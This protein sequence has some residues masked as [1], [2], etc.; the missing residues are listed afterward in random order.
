M[1]FRYNY[2]FAGNLA[3]GNPNAGPISQSSETPLIA[4]AWASVAVSVGANLSNANVTFYHDASALTTTGGATT[5]A[6][7]TD[8]SG[9]SI[10]LGTDPSTSPL[11]TLPMTGLDATLA[12]YASVLSG[13]D[14]TALHNAGAGATLFGAGSPIVAQPVRHWI[15]EEGPSGPV[16]ID[17]VSS[18]AND[19]TLNGAVSWSSNVP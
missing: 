11:N 19:M 10:G 18:P 9:F 4:G 1:I 13:A 5:P 2:N 14:I 3:I 17:Q 12:V 16:A 8:A 6:P 7:V 15:M